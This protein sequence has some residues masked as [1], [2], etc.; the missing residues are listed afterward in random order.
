MH[1][2]FQLKSFISRLAKHIG[3]KTRVVSDHVSKVFINGKHVL[4]GCCRS[5]G[6]NVCEFVHS[7]IHFNLLVVLCPYDVSGWGA[8]GGTGEGERGDTSVE[9]Q[10]SHLRCVCREFAYKP[11]RSYHNKGKVNSPPCINP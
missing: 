6:D 4:K 11:I 1:C 9:L 10:A 5:I 7:I 3:Y 8:S 2:T